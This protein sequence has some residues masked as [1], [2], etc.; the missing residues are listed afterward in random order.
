[1]SGIY[2]YLS[3]NGSLVIVLCG[4]IIVYIV[5]SSLTQ[6]LFIVPTSS[7]FPITKSWVSILLQ[8][9]RTKGLV[10]GFSETIIVQRYAINFELKLSVK[11]EA[12]KVFIIRNSII[13]LEKHFCRFNI[14]YFDF[15]FIFMEIYAIAY[16]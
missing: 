11:Y 12:Y 13:I 16:S 6:Q 15:Y 9:T 10:Y 7:H 2:F 3:G 4:R 14:M 8:K 1:M 5:T